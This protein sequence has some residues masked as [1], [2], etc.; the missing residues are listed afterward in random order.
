MPKL[1]EGDLFLMPGDDKPGRTW[2]VEYVTP[3]G[4][5]V[6]P[7]TKKAVDYETADGVGVHFEAL[8]GRRTQISATSDVE[9]IESGVEF[10]AP[11][12]R[13]SHAK[14]KRRARV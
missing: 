4:A 1:T 14:G 5:S 9:V 11:K 2:L 10:R 7:F 6:R 13:R 8:D 3:S 12:W